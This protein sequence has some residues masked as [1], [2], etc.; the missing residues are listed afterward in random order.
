[1]IVEM[2]TY[3]AV[4]GRAGEFLK[5]Y[6]EL[7]LALQQQYLGGLMGYYVSEVGE[8]NQIVHLWRYESLADR[9]ARRARLDADPGWAVY[10]EAFAKLGAIS[11]QQSTFMK[12]VSFSPT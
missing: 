10:K 7:A 3:T 11:H 4:P 6:E 12:P 9:E 5:L 2:R 8:L 1:M